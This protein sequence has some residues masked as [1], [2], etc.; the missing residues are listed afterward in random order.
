MTTE[1][2]QTKG[3]TGTGFKP[4]D[5][6]ASLLGG[7]GLAR[8]PSSSKHTDQNPG[9]IFQG[10]KRTR[11]NTTLGLQS[12]KHNSMRQSTNNLTIQDLMV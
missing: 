9:Q 3:T 12:N 11:T 6:S 4:Q 10:T 2:S 5:S 7:V 1:T 8:P